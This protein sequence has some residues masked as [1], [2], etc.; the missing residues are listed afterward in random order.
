MHKD[1][2][3]IQLKQPRRRQPWTRKLTTS[4]RLQ[5]VRKRTSNT[6]KPNVSSKKEKNDQ[7]TLFYIELPNWKNA[8]KEARLKAIEVEISPFFCRV[9]VVWKREFI[10]LFKW[11]SAKL[12]MEDG[13]KKL[14]AKFWVKI[15]ASSTILRI[16]T[17]GHPIQSKWEWIKRRSCKLKYGN[18]PIWTPIEV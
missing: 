12:E 13:R 18:L 9:Q 5:W 10:F 8:N 4:A 14:W 6:K 16:P 17:L 7:K 1:K 3:P 2:I 15:Y 11:K